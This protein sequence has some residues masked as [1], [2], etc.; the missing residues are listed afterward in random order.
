[1]NSDFTNAANLRLQFN[2]N[3]D[4]DRL[5]TTSSRF[6]FE[7]DKI[8]WNARENAN[9]LYIGNINFVHVN[10]NTYVTCQIHGFCT[11]RSHK[12]VGQLSG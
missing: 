12:Y 11:V 6:M 1:M 9:S 2:E 7:A 4:C 3:F 8:A 10:L 5:L